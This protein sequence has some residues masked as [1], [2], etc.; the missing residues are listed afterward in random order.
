MRFG[1]KVYFVTGGGRGIGRAIAKRLADEGARVWIADSDAHAGADAADEYGD[2]VRF[3]RCNVAKEADVRR[4]LT[5]AVKWGGRLDG[6][7]NNAG[8]ADPASGP[9]E[10]LALAVW[11]AWLLSS[12][13]GFVTGSV[14]Q[15]RRHDSQDELRV[16][17]AAS[18]HPENGA[19]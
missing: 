9:V 11:D 10:D 16:I 19:A 6:L 7:V 18:T 3:E 1:S 8:I 15:R 4:A 13:A 12:E 14:Y 5:A 2:R 17:H